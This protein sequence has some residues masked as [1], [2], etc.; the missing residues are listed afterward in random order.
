M[1]FAS[2]VLHS[3]LRRHPMA[4]L[5]ELKHALGTNST[6]TVFRKLK[7]LGYRTSYSP[8]RQVLHLG[9]NPPF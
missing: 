6:M 1:A 9:R 5:D 3:L 4:T 2:E 8:P 7:A